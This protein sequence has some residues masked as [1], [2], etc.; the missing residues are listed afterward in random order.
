M[1]ARGALFRLSSNF[2]NSCAPSLRPA[3]TATAS[4]SHQQTDLPLNPSL[5]QGFSRG[6]TTDA[7][8]PTGSAPGLSQNSSQALNP[9]GSQGSSFGLT[10]GFS[11]GLSTDAAGMG[12]TAPYRLRPENVQRVIEA[13]LTLV[14]ELVQLKGETVRRLEKDAEKVPALFGLP[15]GHNSSFQQ[16]TWPGI[17]CLC[18]LQKVLKPSLSTISA[19]STGSPHTN[20]LHY[21]CEESIGAENCRRALQRTFGAKNQKPCV[22]VDSY[23]VADVM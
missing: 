17:L 11:R 4:I 7:P 6:L 10:E 8:E 9:G 5:N 16:G 18:V 13:A 23:M 21:P 1:A 15:L 3:L 19:F 2:L 12:H 20:C 22:S 14:R